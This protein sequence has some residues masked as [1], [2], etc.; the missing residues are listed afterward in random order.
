[1]Y[2]KHDKSDCILHE[3]ANSFLQTDLTKTKELIRSKEFIVGIEKTT[4]N[5]SY[6]KLCQQ[7]NNSKEYT[8]SMNFA[9]SVT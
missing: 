3:I 9:H 2:Y 1:M 8:Y 5:F 4:T 6:R 7:L